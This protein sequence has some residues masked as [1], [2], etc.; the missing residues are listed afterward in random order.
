TLTAHHRGGTAVDV[1]AGEVSVQ[2]PRPIEELVREVEAAGPCPRTESV[3]ERLVG[4]TPLDAGD[5][6]AHRALSGAEVLLETGRHVPG[7]RLDR[8]A[9]LIAVVQ[10]VL[11]TL[12][13]GHG[14]EGADSPATGRLARQLGGTED[15]RGVRAVGER[16]AI[17]QAA[18]WR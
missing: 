16:R 2:L 18:L 17:G 12:L 10:H 1:A 15:R 9:A 6:T 3:G 4:E 8:H 5:D 11:R 14:S 7:A 13:R